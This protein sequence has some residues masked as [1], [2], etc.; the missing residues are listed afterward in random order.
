M[1]VRELDCSTDSFVSWFI[2]SF[3]HSLP[4]QCVQSSK[5]RKKKEKKADER[6]DIYVVIPYPYKH[7]LNHQKPRNI[8]KVFRVS[9]IRSL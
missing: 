8:R 1:N 7:L 2:R 6:S 9:K 3:V 4:R 5:K